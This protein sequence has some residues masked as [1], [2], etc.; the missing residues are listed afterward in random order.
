MKTNV[1]ISTCKKIPLD[2]KWDE[3]INSKFISVNSDLKTVVFFEGFESK[4]TA[5]I[6]GNTPIE[7]GSYYYEIKVKENLFGTAVM[8]G[9]GTED[10]T[11]NYNDYNYCNLIGLDS[12]GWGLSHKGTV[13]HDGK[14]RQFCDAFFEADTLIGILLH[15]KKIHYFINGQYKGIAFDNVKT[16]KKLYPVVSSTAAD[17]ELELVNSFR[18]E[19]SLKDLC[20]HKVQNLFKN[21]IDC[22]QIPKSLILCLKQM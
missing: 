15:D 12:E 20:L 8:F 2:W 16:N 9:F 14:S 4:G 10:I 3:K 13:W 19:Y 5:G 17:I 18:L 7:S 1:L 6:K 11:L 22:L 21:E